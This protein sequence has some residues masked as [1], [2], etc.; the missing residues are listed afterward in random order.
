MATPSLAL[1][2]PLLLTFAVGSLV[3]RG[4]GCTINDLADRNIDSKVARTKTRPLASGAITEKQAVAFLAGQLSVGLAILL[5]L[6]NTCIAL[7][8]ASLLLVGT[9]PLM[10][11]VTYWPQAF[12]GLTF[13]YG[14]LMGWA[15]VTGSL[16]L[17]AVLPLYAAGICWTLVYDTI[18]AHQ[19]RED[20][21]LVGVKSTALLFGTDTK[22]WLSLFSG[23]TVA[24]LVAAGM[25]SGMAWP[26]YLGTG[27]GAAHL[28]WQ[29]NTLDINN[30]KDCM[31]K[32]VANKWFGAIIFAG[33]ELSHL[34]S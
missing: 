12:L 8:T 16:Y 6:N 21:L 2:M 4:A 33:I 17:P 34:L 29:L 7:G 20:D 1:Q 9:Y 5:T 24:G 3:L 10:K 13:N 11:R 23:G 18:Y 25:A 15:A 22:R 19:D 27:L 32:F 30:G 31:A 14:V 26:Y 28:A